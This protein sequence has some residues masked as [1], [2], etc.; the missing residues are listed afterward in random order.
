M[1][2]C[3]LL[4]IYEYVYVNVAVPWT[5]N[6]VG[7]STSQKVSS[8]RSEVVRT[9]TNSYISVL[10]WSFFDDFQFLT[11]FLTMSLVCSPNHLT[12]VVVNNVPLFFCI[13]DGPYMPTLRLL[14]QCN[15]T[16]PSHHSC[17]T[18]LLSQ[19]N[20]IL[21]TYMFV[22]TLRSCNFHI[23]EWNTSRNKLGFL[24]VSWEC[25]FWQLIVLVFCRPKHNEEVSSW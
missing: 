19:H 20:I 8:D 12:L 13:R 22:K 9:R 24:S 17:Y 7:R 23:L 21:S 18:V 6:S 11:V 15:I 2:S 10:F 4:D 5:W 25:Q 16:L 14:H 1:I 3:S